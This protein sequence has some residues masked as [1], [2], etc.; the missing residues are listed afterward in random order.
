MPPIEWKCRS[1]GVDYVQVSAQVKHDRVVHG[2]GPIAFSR[3]YRVRAVIL[4]PG[5]ASVARE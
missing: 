4:D 3:R 5:V 1:V 2:R